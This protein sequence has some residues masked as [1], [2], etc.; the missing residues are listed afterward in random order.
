MASSIPI[1]DQARGKLAVDASGGRAIAPSA[2]GGSSA[3]W[4]RS[5]AQKA[6]RRFRSQPQ[7]W[8]A[9]RRRGMLELKRRRADDLP[10]MTPSQRFELSSAERRNRVPHPL[11]K[12]LSGACRRV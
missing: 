12:Q 6:R 9:A 7:I 8:L 11:F 4:M 1:A 5:S 2:A 10:A 3:S